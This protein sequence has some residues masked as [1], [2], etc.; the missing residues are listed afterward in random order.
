MTNYYSF[1]AE[2]GL[3]CGSLVIVFSLTSGLISRALKLSNPLLKILL[4]IVS[5][6]I[7]VYLCG[8]AGIAVLKTDVLGFRWL[9]GVIGLGILLIP[10]QS[11]VLFVFKELLDKKLLILI[12]I[13]C[14]IE[15]AYMLILSYLSKLAGCGW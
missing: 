3:I 7:Y 13:V 8:I 10:V 1:H 12:F 14:I 9:W 2:I 11:V 4:I 6:L 15:V 5:T